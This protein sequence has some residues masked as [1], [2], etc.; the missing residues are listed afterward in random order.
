M[1]Y[2]QT[3]T[4][5]KDDEQMN[6]AASRIAAHL[7]VGTLVTGAVGF[8]LVLLVNRGINNLDTLTGEVGKLNQQVAVILAK[9]EA[10]EKRDATQDSRLEKHREQ[11]LELERI[12]SAIH[13]AQ[14]PAK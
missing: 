2:D 12:V 9:N 4:E 6:R 7:D 10:Q 5:P 13:R 14:R 3:N 8:V 11:L 1:E